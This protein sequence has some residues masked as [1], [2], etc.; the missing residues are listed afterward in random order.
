MGNTEST[1]LKMC[2]GNSLYTY[3]NRKSLKEQ[4]NTQQ[5]VGY[6]QTKQV[7][8]APQ[9]R[10]ASQQ[11][12][13]QCQM[14]QETYKEEP[15]ELQ[16]VSTKR[17][18]AQQEPVK[19][20][21][22]FNVYVSCIKDQLQ[23]E[24][25]LPA[26]ETEAQDDTQAIQQSM[27]ENSM[28]CFEGLFG[29]VII[30]DNGLALYT[31][32]NGEKYCEDFDADGIIKTFPLGISDGG[33]TKS[34][35]FNDVIERD[36]CFDAMTSKLQGSKDAPPSY[37][38]VMSE[39]E[40]YALPLPEPEVQVDLEETESEEE[41]DDDDH[42][43]VFE[44]LGGMQVIV[45][46]DNLI[47]FTDINGDKHCRPYNPRTLQKTFPSGISGGDLPKSIWFD[48]EQERDLCFAL[49][50]WN[51]ADLEEEYQPPEEDIKEY[52]GLYGAVFLHPDGIIEY[53]SLT[54]EMVRTYFEPAEVAGTFPMGI[55]Y[56]RL[57]KTIWFE[58]QADREKCLEDMRKIL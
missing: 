52:T 41:E 19:K 28:R 42:V 44:G 30:H 26:L 43:K 48:E 25:Q 45:H 47:L 32:I 55:S 24:Q 1:G 56:G 49:M 11:Q 10:Q 13:G 14:Q 33:L 18:Q 20:K 4:M 36:E 34:I 5:R 23:E 38:Q 3:A 31:D 27:R 8:A 40:K 22:T 39:P 57:P 15:I 17:Q 51:L 53:T 9:L 2:S 29:N 58:T 6:G 37:E 12:F 50:Q 7:Y 46:E 54:G 16:V 21:D 35:W